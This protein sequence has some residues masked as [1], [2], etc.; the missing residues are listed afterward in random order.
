MNSNSENNSGDNPAVINEFSLIV[1][2]IKIVVLAIFLVPLAKYTLIS[3]QENGNSSSVLLENA[4]LALENIT[5]GENITKDEKVT[6]NLIKKVIV[7]QPACPKS[8]IFVI[9]D[10][11]CSDIAF[12]YYFCTPEDIHNPKKHK[13]PRHARN[14]S[15][16]DPK[17]KK[18]PDCV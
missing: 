3:K 2:A 15:N 17:G 6:N 10:E 12:R 9:L 8:Q 13:I 14:K 4:T 5:A 11:I 7:S 16:K 1:T 18:C